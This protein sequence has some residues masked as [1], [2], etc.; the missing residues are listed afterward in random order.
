M[1]YLHCLLSAAIS[2]M[3]SNVLMSSSTTLLLVFF[4]LSTGMASYVPSTSSSIAL[5]SMLFS[6]HLLTSP[7]H[8]D[9]GL[10]FHNLCSRFF[11]PYLLLTS[12]LVIL[13]CH[14]I[15]DIIISQRSMININTT[16]SLWVEVSPGSVN[17]FSPKAFV[18]I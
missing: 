6:S 12:S 15:L 7:N 5:L 13:S 16:C 8:L 2:S 11:T 17:P 3:M 4:G 9:L 18:K 1:S 10:F 14:L